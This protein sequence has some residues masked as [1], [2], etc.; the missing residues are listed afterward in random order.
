MAGLLDMVDIESMPVGS[1]EVIEEVVTDTPYEDSRFQAA[2]D[3]IIQYENFAPFGKIDRSEGN[4]PETWK[5][6]AGY[7]SDTKTLEDGTVIPVTE[8]MPYSVEE[9]D[10]DIAR[11]L[12]DDFIPAANNV[13]G[14]ENMSVMPTP[15]YAALISIAYN[16]GEKNMKGLTTLQSAVDSLD[17]AKIADAIEGYSSL[18]EGANAKRRISEA[19]FIRE[20]M[21]NIL[22]QKIDEYNPGMEEFDS[23]TMQPWE[24]VPY[25]LPESS[26]EQQPAMASRRR[27]RTLATIA[28]LE[29]L[30]ALSGFRG[31]LGQ[32]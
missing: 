5:Y 21:D 24:G 11:R 23:G 28:G 12:R 6:R 22:P 8:N 29:P 31:L 26:Q 14:Q 15:I 27:Q 7:G 3:L 18:N 9:A 4:P 32:D 16:F 30:Q 25:R 19:S 17:P 20:A 2:R 13:F 10:R 1:S